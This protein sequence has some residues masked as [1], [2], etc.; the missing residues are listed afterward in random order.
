M[1]WGKQYKVLLILGNGFD[2]SL[3]LKTSYT[4]FMESELFKQRVDIQYYPYGRRNEHDKNIHNYLTIQK[5]LSNWIDVEEE[6]KKYA[7]G[8]RVEYFNMQG[9]LISTQNASENV[10]K[11]NFNIL[12]LDLQTYISSLD[13]SALNRDAL[14]LRL[15]RN[16]AASKN[17]DIVTF[18]YTDLNKLLE[19][20]ARS[21]ISY[22]HGNIK[23]GIILGFQRFKEMASGYDYMIKSE[24][25]KYKSCHLPSK[26]READEIIVYG[27]SLG[28]TDHCY[29]QPFFDEQTS[30]NAKP[31]RFTVFTL[32]N[33]SK[34]QVVQQ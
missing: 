27:H 24:S 32:N 16:V 19:S 13:Y 9:G 23:D 6:L 29:F 3:G 2:L 10:I 11:T 31:K 28:S 21:S 1:K 25:P 20:K 7:T 30:A 26:M 18:N 17:N 33:V 8:K 15:F 22:I 4:D 12:C 34:E 14:S 5:G